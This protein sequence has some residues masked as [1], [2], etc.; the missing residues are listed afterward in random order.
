MASLEE[1]RQN[2]IEKLNFLIEKGIDPYPVESHQDYTC[3]EAR[4]KFEVLEKKNERHSL[5]G[6][7][8]AL[9]EQGKLIFL[10]FNDGTGSFQALLKS[11]EP[12]PEE[13]FEL[14]QKAFDIGDFVEI[15][16]TFMLTKS[17]EKTV[18][19][20]NVR[21][22]AKSLRPLPEKWHGLEDVETRYRE[23]ELDILSDNEVK[24]RFIIRSKI[25]S[26][27]RR[28]LDERGFLEFETPVLQ[29][30]PGGANARP[31][32]THHNAL[33]IDLYLRIATEI[34]LKRLIVAG[35]NKVYEIG[36]L[37]RNE[38]IDHAHN[39]EFTSME[40]YWA[41]TNKEEY[42]SF[43]ED[44]IK[45]VVQ[46][47]TG[48]QKVVSG[49]RE[50]DF[51]KEWP[52]KSFREAVI[53]ASGIDIDEHKTIDSLKKI[54]SDKKLNVDFSSSVG[55]GD[56]YDQLFKKTTRVGIKDPTWITEYPV[57]L[58]PLANRVPSDRSKSASAQLIINGD[59]LINAYYY[60]LND[61]L[62]QRSRF[63]EQEKLREEGSENAQPLDEQFLRSL[64]YGMPPTSGVGIGID[65]LAMLLSNT[66]NIK[67]VILFPTLRPRN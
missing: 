59:E 41:Y 43:L 33:D 29:E 31:F 5:V 26:A 9:R 53:D 66:D 50:I 6:R 25:V 57:E 61:P 37:F 27:M 8:L 12:L 63:E 65:R 24:E 60:E 10:T 20:E 21:M 42:L 18:L 3:A 19:A 40:M 15:K 44:L 7:I 13:Q 28:Y 58:K 54:V 16:G 22:L 55:L 48:S 35:Y 45:Y 51:G 39:P 1:I 30:T 38:G 17:G 47:A 11:G 62:D 36:R 56:H 32:V 4:E 23:R 49:D 67:E 46:E 52:R 2:R 64:E 34:H 14:F